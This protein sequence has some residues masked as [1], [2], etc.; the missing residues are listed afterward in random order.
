MYFVQVPQ[1]YHD[2][3]S[4]TFSTN[5]HE[6][7]YYVVHNYRQVGTYTE[8]VHC[9]IIVATPLPLFGIRPRPLPSTLR[10]RR[11]KSTGFFLYSI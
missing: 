5:L 10:N 3:A 4:A 9:H 1:L 2:D 6:T 8:Y 7:D 11:G